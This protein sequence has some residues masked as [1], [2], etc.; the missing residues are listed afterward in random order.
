V[1]VIGMSFCYFQSIKV[2]FSGSLM[3]L[4]AGLPRVQLTSHPSVRKQLEKGTNISRCEE[5]QLMLGFRIRIRGGKRSSVKEPYNQVGLACVVLTIVPNC[6]YSFNASVADQV[7]L[8]V[9]FTP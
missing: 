7:T 2:L 6:N 8:P 4:T 9:Y 5:R 1:L 3:A